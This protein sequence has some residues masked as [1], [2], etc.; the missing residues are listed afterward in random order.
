MAYVEDVREAGGDIK[1]ANL[2]PKVYN[3]FDLL[4]FPMLFDIEDTEEE[5]LAR[6]EENAEDA[7]EPSDAPGENRIA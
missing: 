6:F 1:I 4:G 3:V 7:P 2:K 5:A